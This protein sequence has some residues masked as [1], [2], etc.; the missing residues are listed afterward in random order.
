MVSLQHTNAGFH[1]PYVPSAATTIRSGPTVLYSAIRMAA[2]THHASSRHIP[3]RRN[4]SRWVQRYVLGGVLIP[5]QL[6][7]APGLPPVRMTGPEPL[8]CSQVP[9]YLRSANRWE[10]IHGDHTIAADTSAH[11]TVCTP[12]QMFL[13]GQQCCTEVRVVNSGDAVYSLSNPVNQVT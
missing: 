7:T 9:L 6:V 5:T 2:A 13:T 8:S 3:P 10:G 1:P 4:H 11:Q 12:T